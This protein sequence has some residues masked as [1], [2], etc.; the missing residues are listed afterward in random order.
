MASA[1]IRTVKALAAQEDYFTWEGRD[2][3]GKVARGE[4]RAASTSLARWALRRQ[5]IVP[6]KL[7][8]RSAAV[9]RAIKSKDIAHFTRQLGTLLA[10]GLPVLQGLDLLARSHPNERMMRMINEIRVAVQ[11]GASLSQAMRQHP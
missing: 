11:N 6:H 1:N 9:G 2:K 4:L 3:N 10:A 5:G 8:R 7:K